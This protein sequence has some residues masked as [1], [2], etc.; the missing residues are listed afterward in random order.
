MTIVC[1]YSNF[2]HIIITTST[3]LHHVPLL[4]K[5]QLHCRWRIR[6]SEECNKRRE[7]FK[8]I[9]LHTM[10]FKEGIRLHTAKSSGGKIR[11]CRIDVNNL[12][13]LVVKR[14]SKDGMKNK[15]VRRNE[16]TNKQSK[17]AMDGSGEKSENHTA[18]IVSYSLCIKTLDDIRM[19]RKRFSA[20]TCWWAD[21]DRRD[22]LVVTDWLTQ[23]LPNTSKNS[24]SPF[25]T[26]NNPEIILPWI[27]RESG[28]FRLFEI[29]TSLLIVCTRRK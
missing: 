21:Y 27:E 17:Q 29:V 23:G 6:C 19:W 11:W 14:G 20:C 13:I 28:E 5:P 22:L 26:S 10:A 2:S 12:M 18:W 3:L 15:R 16:R 7:F 8:E 24:M 9:R 4:G 1:G 25:C